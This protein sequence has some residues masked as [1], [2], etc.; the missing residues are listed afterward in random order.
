MLFKNI[1]GHTEIKLRLIQSVNDN[2]ISHA[3]LFLSKEGVGGIGLAIAYCQYISCNNKQANDSCGECASCLKFNKLIHPD[4]HFAFPVNTTSKIT[5]DPISALFL[6]DWRNIISQNPYL[7]LF[8]WLE[9]IGIENK[10][11]AIGVNESTEIIKKLNLKPY[12]SNYK[13]M[14]IWMAEKMNNQAANK[15][16][17]LLEEPPDKT[18]FILVCEQQEQLLSTIISRTQLIKIS[19]ISD[20]AIRPKLMFDYQLSEDQAQEILNMAEGNYALAQKLAQESEEDVQSLNMQ[21]FR[22]WMLLCFNKKTIEL[23]AFIEQIDQ[24]KRERQK[25]FLSYCLHLVRESLVNAY[26]SEQVAKGIGKEKL[27]IN[28]FYTRIVGTD[29]IEIVEEL[30]KAIYHI[31]RN[32]HAKIL[33]MDLSLKFFKWFSKQNKL[34]A[35]ANAH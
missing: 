34:L 30:N 17:K 18:L 14:I 11:G 7:D 33:F 1:I 31:E 3:Q 19:T 27:F 32:A 22:D 20:D 5:K 6:N 2:R 16:L 28:K 15:L 12:E 29:I 4:L 25:K 24:L 35:E 23:V 8:T 26:E 10:Q 9:F 13:F 21:L